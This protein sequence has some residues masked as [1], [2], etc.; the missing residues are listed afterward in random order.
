MRMDIQVFNI[1]KG[2]RKNPLFDET[3]TDCTVNSLGEYNNGLLRTAYSRN[4]APNSDIAALKCCFYPHIGAV[5]KFK[6][7]RLCEH[8]VVFEF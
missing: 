8:T 4:P 3:T 6:K 2:I 5:Y 7:P 1:G